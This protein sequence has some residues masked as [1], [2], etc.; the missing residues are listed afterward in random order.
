VFWKKL[1][2]VHLFYYFVVFS[3]G[4]IPTSYCSSSEVSE[5]QN[6]IQDRVFLAIL[7]ALTMPSNPICLYLHP[8]NVIRAVD[9]ILSRER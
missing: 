2:A 3:M 4:N 9:I 5:L 6:A 8:W 7:M 1:W